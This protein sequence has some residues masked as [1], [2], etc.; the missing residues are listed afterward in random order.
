MTMTLDCWAPYSLLERSKIINGDHPTQ[1]TST[2][3]CPC[4]DRL[5][6]RRIIGRW[7]IKNADHLQIMPVGQ[8]QNP[9]ASAEARM[10]ST[11][12]EADS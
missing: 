3:S 6:E 9:V 7:M 8:R 12:E 10:E 1:P 5:A 4:A 2:L 11:V